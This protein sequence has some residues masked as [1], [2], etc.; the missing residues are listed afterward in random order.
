MNLAEKTQAA[1]DAVIE[2]LRGGNP[3]AIK[4]AVKVLDEVQ[5]PLPTRQDMKVRLEHMKNR[6]CNTHALEQEWS[7]IFRYVANNAPSSP[8]DEMSAFELA[9]RCRTWANELDHRGW[10][11]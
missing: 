9:E 6:M 4:R 8:K 7:Y 1:K 5:S 3:V 10:K 11:E 2:A